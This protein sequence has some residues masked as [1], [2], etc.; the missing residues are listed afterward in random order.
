MGCNVFFGVLL[1]V[2]YVGEQIFFEHGIFSCS[3][4]GVLAFDE[5]VVEHPSTLAFADMQG[6]P[7]LLTRQGLW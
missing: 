3:L 4:A 2:L 5:A 7:H 6:A 1:R